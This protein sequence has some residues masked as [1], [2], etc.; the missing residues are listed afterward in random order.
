VLGFAGLPH[1]GEASAQIEANRWKNLDKTDRRALSDFL[2]KYPN[3]THR[4]E[5][6]SFL[7]EMDSR[8]ADT[9]GIQTA[10]DKFN[11]AFDHQQTRELKDIWPGATSKYLEQL[12][13]P[14]GYKV[15]FILKPRTL[16]PVIQ[17]GTA[18]ISCD[19]T[20]A[21]TP[22]GGQTKT[23]RTLVTVRL[24]KNGDRWLITDPFG[25]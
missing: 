19:L 4:N 17:A 8:E 23:N 7:N 10:L 24:R 25:K 14:G 1:A 18:A 20:T 3:S 5:A 11:A 2:G 13:P 21:T 16:E 15:L 6:Q 9:K 12:H 22:P